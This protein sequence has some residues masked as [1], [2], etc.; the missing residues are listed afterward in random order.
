MS[1]VN[2]TLFETENGNQ[3]SYS[4]QFNTDFSSQ[5]LENY[6]HQII[7]VPQQINDTLKI[8]LFVGPGNS[9][10]IVHDF[11]IGLFP[12]NISNWKLDVEYRDNQGVKLKEVKTEQA[13]GE[14]E[15]RPIKEGTL[16]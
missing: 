3:N 14:A 7:S 1:T 12:N 5:T 13:E 2:Y 4:L 10:H 6:G 11:E 9:S 8:K 15:P 16:K